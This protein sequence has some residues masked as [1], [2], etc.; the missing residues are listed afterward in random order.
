MVLQNLRNA[1]GSSIKAICIRCH[2]KYCYFIVAILLFGL[3]FAAK[4]DE[5]VDRYPVWLPQWLW[6]VPEYAYLLT[7][8]NTILLRQK[9]N[10]AS[11]LAEKVPDSK[12]LDAAEQ[13]AT[14]SIARMF[15]TRDFTA[16]SFISRNQLSGISLAVRIDPMFSDEAKETIKKGVDR[17]LEV[18]L[19]PKVIEIA[20][21]RSTNM[22]TPAPIKYEMEKNAPK[23]DELG[24]QIFTENYAFMARQ[25]VQPLD[26][27]QFTEHLRGA[28]HVSNGDPRLL[29]ISQYTTQIWWGSSYYNYF[30]DP[31]KNLGRD[32]T[33]QGFLYIRLNSDKLKEPTEGWN[34]PDFWASKIGHEILHN[35]GYWHPAYTSIEERDQ[36]NKGNSWAFI[37]SYEKA[38]YDKL[39]GKN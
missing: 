4:A 2:V 29:V 16:D 35:L 10:T 39:K 20:F 33:A 22:P 7:P 31:I 5:E 21:N 6:D 25:R 8:E 30:D 18:A 32:T 3:S 12:A 17:Y 36:N 15:S 14:S 37:Y 11:A 23:L 9:I 34:D 1:F 38:V 19:D 24:R 26:T 27:K 13:D 28:L